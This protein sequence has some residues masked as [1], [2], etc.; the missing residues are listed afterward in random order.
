MTRFN[1]CPNC[2]NVP[3]GLFGGAYFP[4]YECRRCQTCYCYKCGDKRCP[5][6][7]S[8]ERT[9]AGTCWGPPRRQ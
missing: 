4:I 6:C 5:N 8:R 2:G 1:Q 3:G 7:G 9:K